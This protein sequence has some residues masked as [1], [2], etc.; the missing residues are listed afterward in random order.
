MA[1]RRATRAAGRRSVDDQ[2]PM[3]G[4]GLVHPQ[5]IAHRHGYEPAR[6]KTPRPWRGCGSMGAVLLGKTTLCEFGWKGVCDSPLTGISRNPWN[7][8]VTCGGSSGGAGIAAALGMGALH[9]G[10][11][12]AGVHP[13]SRLVLRRLRAEGEFRAGADLSDRTHAGHL[14]CRAAGSHRGWTRHSC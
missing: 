10:S 12:G 9:I 7:T 1:A 8:E 14:P 13:H 2:G 6:P 5:G 11:D 4:D 3:D